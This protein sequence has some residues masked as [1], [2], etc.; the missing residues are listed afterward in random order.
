MPRH[1]H[2]GRSR[3]KGGGWCVIPI[4]IISAIGSF[5]GNSFNSTQNPDNHDDFN[6]T[7]LLPANKY[8]NKSIEKLIK[9]IEKERMFNED[10]DGNFMW[11]FYMGLLSII[12]AIYTCFTYYY[13]E[14]EIHKM[15]NKFD[16]AKFMKI[17]TEAFE[18][19]KT[20]I[21]KKIQKEV[22]ERKK[23]EVTENSDHENDTVE[24]DL[25]EVEDL[26]EEE[27]YNKTIDKQNDVDQNV[28]YL[29]K[30]DLKDNHQTL[31]IKNSVVYITNSED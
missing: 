17:Q 28:V 16:S 27:E 25:S 7:S 23:Q 21:S 18:E 9:T 2:K 31:N 30:D 6:S 14:K 20:I 11:A 24:S 1:R 5:V 29:D 8:I 26:E 10:M 19:A 4:I 13:H 12:L 3:K 15:D 22:E